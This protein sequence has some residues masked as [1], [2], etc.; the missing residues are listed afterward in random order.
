MRRV[1]D[2]DP[3]SLASRSRRAMD[4]VAHGGRRARRGRSSTGDDP[5]VASSIAARPSAVASR[6]AGGPCRRRPARSPVAP[7]QPTSASPSRKRSPASTSTPG[8]GLDLGAHERREEHAVRG[9]EIGDVPACRRAARDGRASWR[10]CRPGSATSCASG[11]A[12]SATGRR[13]RITTSALSG[14]GAPGRRDDRPRRC[15]VA[16]GDDRLLDAR[17]R[18]SAAGRAVRTRAAARSAGAPAS[19]APTIAETGPE[20]LGDAPRA[21]PWASA[22]APTAR[23]R[24]P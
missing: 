21:R 12:G 9:V 15:G 2:V 19:G 3:S 17:P 23:A 14:I 7:Q 5:R 16:L 18:G 24:A 4:P 22:S 13:P 20:R 10:S 1:D 6:V 8:V 11:K